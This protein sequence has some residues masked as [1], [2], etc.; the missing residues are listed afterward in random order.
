MPTVLAPT[1]ADL[2]ADWLREHDMPGRRSKT[3]ITKLRRERER[4]RPVPV[5]RPS[6]RVRADRLLLRRIEAE[7]ARR[8]G[9]TAIPDKH[10]VTRLGIADRDRAAGLTLVAAHGWRYYSSREGA[11][12]ASLVYLYGVDDAGPWAVRVAGT[13]ATVAATLEWL[14]P[15]EVRDA[16]ARGRRVRRQGDVYAVETA[17]R[18]DGAGVEELP[19]SHRWNPHTRYLTH[20]PTDGQFGKHRPVRLPW[21][22]R[23]VRQRAYTMA[24]TGGRGYAD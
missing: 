18:Y 2:L 11:H 16:A 14:T 6:A 19:A 13:C 9:E 24:R 12:R 1:G 15:T 8:G 23:F 10:S 3:A 4:R 5:T 17:A 22:V 20:C 7:I 21:P